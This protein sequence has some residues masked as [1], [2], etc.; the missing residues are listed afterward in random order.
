MIKQNKHHLP[1]KMDRTPQHLFG[2]H[3]I[4][5]HQGHARLFWAVN[6]RWLQCPPPPPLWDQPSGLRGERLEEWII[7]D[8]ACVL[9]NGAATLLNRAAR[10]LS[11]SDIPLDR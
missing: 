11:S 7:A 10:G 4:G 9:N 2:P 8:S 1:L 3:P 6:G 5:C